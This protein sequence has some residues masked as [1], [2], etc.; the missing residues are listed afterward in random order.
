MKILEQLRYD[1]L[2]PGEA[3][4]SSD[5]RYLKQLNAVLENEDK[6]LKMLPDEVKEAYEK[7][8]DSKEELAVTDRARIFT[9]G[10]RM[11]AK[12]MLEVMQ[13]DAPKK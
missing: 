11:G 4:N 7:C 12:I 13:E 10:F 8:T 6:L 3:K 1:G 9:A 5:P 2:Y